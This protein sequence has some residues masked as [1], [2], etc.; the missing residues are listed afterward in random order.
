MKIKD[1]GRNEVYSLEEIKKDAVKFDMLKEWLKYN[2]KGWADVFLNKLKDSKYISY[3]NYRDE[4]IY[5]TKLSIPTKCALTLFDLDITD[6]QVDC[7]ELSKEQIDEMCSVLLSKGKDYLTS[8]EFALN[9]TDNSD[10][11]ISDEDEFYIT[12]KQYDRITITYDKFMELF[13]EK[14]VE[15]SETNHS[16]DAQKYALSTEQGYKESDNKCNYELD[17]E[18]IHDLAMRI[19]NEPK[20]KPYNWQKPI[21]IKRLSNA[22]LRH[23]IEV[24]KGNFDDKGEL[25]HLLAIAANAMFIYYQK[26]NN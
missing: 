11:L 2:D 1:L 4:W 10:F 19:Q 22:M 14:A 12:N 15:L 5:G 20:Y 13:W 24:K 21:D 18:F 8:K 16:E 25:G 26:K 9:R 7:S 6:Y 23:A 17:F 3:N